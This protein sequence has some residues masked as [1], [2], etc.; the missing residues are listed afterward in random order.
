MACKH[1]KGGAAP[2]MSGL[3]WQMIEHWSDE[4]VTHVYNLLIAIHADGSSPAHWAWK[5]LSL[6]QKSRIISLPKIFDPCLSLKSSESFGTDSR[7]GMCGHSSLNTTCYT[8]HK[9]LTCGIKAVKT[10]QFKLSMRLKRLSKRQPSLRSPHGTSQEPSTASVMLLPSSA[11]IALVSH[12]LFVQRS[13]ATMQGQK[14][15]SR[16]LWRL[17][18]GPNTS[19]LMAQLHPTLTL[20][21][22]TPPHP[23]L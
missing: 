11:Y 12:R 2:G 13:W 19:N 21:P 10:Q 3:T 20:T 4:V 22:L 9:M 15:S 16:A 18:T 1:T 14:Y 17:H 6:I 23:L 7:Y 5:W 8:T